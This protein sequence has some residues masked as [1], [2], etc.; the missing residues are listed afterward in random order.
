MIATNTK[1]Q[2]CSK[3]ITPYLLLYL[4]TIRTIKSDKLRNLLCKK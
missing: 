3:E 1:V 4:R 2:L